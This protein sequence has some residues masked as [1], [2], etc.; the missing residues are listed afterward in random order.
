MLK[1]GTPPALVLSAKKSVWRMHDHADESEKAFQQIRK[2]IL[3]ASN[4]ACS[5][6]TLQ[7]SKF[8]EVHHADDDHKN[9]KPENLYCSCP[10]CHQVFH[11]GLAGM[12]EGGDL[13]YLPELSQ[14]EVNQLALVIWMVTATDQTQFKDAKQAALFTRLAGRAKTLEGM[15]GNRRGTVLLRLKEALRKTTL[16]AKFPPEFIDRIKLSHLSPTLLSNALM[17]LSE[18][19]YNNRADLLGGLRMLPCATRFR[20]RIKHWNAEASAVLPIP[21]WYNIVPEDALH[22]IILTCQ[23]RITMASDTESAG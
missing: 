4:Y 19:E 10:L 5:F 6:C 7:S 3:E 16:T 17:A 1:Q 14:A 22:A 13:V 18:T 9:N 15:L 11:I 12:K 23:E 2:T 20:E 21:A 8:Q